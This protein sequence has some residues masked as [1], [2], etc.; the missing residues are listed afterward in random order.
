MKFKKFNLE[1][2][3][4]LMVGLDYVKNASNFCPLKAIKKSLSGIYS[5]FHFLV[6][7]R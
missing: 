7:L 5:M 6:E 2:I 1:W 4:G 3:F